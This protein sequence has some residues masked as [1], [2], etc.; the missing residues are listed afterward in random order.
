MRSL[1]LAG[2]IG[3]AD[4][5]WVGAWSCLEVWMAQPEIFVPSGA[6]IDDRT[7]FVTADGVRYVQ[8]WLVGRAPENGERVFKH[9]FRLIYRGESEMFGVLAEESASDS[10][11]EDLAAWVSQRTA[12][13]IHERLQRRGS[14]LTPEQL[15]NPKHWDARRELAG[16]WRDYRKWSK[17]VRSGGTARV[18]V[19][20]FSAPA[21][22]D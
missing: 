17:R 15:A 22:S 6:V 10:Q 12:S 21:S 11:V 4:W 3:I 2:T 18:Y 8:S 9:E 20:G 19:P 14:S 16:I 1:P 5:W 7:G 13:K